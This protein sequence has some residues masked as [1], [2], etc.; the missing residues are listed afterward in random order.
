M[1][2]AGE[3]PGAECDPSGTGGWGGS[4]EECDGSVGQYPGESDAERKARLEK[5]LEESVG[6]F[7][8]VLADEQK[9]ISIPKDS[10]AARAAPVA[11]V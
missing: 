7:D 9:E 3:M 2:G 11:G 10:A 4:G 8:E 5:T 1:G 6:G